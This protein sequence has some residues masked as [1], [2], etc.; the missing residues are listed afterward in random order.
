MNVKIYT[1]Y[2]D[3]M[4]NPTPPRTGAA[5]KGHAGQCVY[6]CHYLAATGIF[7]LL[8]MSTTCHTKMRGGWCVYHPV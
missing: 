8:R 7:C 2:P 6:K 1:A 4:V 3:F 5:L